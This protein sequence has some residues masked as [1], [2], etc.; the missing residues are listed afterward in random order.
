M[1]ND[2]KLYARVQKKEP[3]E[4]DVVVAVNK[5]DLGGAV[6]TMDQV[7]EFANKYQIKSVF[8]TSAKDDMNVTEAFLALVAKIHRK[9]EVDP[10][11]LAKLEN[12]ERLISKKDKCM[13]M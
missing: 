4:I 8:E 3:S 13:I 7:H 12:G 9:V 6:C 10:K 2:L 11:L 5:C 1:E